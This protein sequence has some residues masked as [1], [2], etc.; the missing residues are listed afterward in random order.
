MSSINSLSDLDSNLKFLRNSLNDVCDHNA[1]MLEARVSQVQRNPRQLFKLGASREEMDRLN[2]F[3]QHFND[4]CDELYLNFQLAKE[5][6]ER[7][8]QSKEGHHGNEEKPKSDI[9]STEKIKK[10][11]D[12]IAFLDK[13]LELNRNNT[14]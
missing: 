7:E 12:H 2:S 11:N 4:V 6:L 3:E 9:L 10:Q 13:V 14:S 1:K 5:T 8:F